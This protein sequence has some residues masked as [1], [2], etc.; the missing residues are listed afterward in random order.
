MKRLPWRFADQGSGR[1]IFTNRT[2]NYTPFNSFGAGNSWG[3][4]PWQTRTG[5]RVGRP[6]LIMG[7]ELGE[8]GSNRFACH[9]LPT[10]NTPPYFNTAEG[11]RAICKPFKKIE[12]RSLS[13]TSCTLPAGAGSPVADHTFTEDDVERVGWIIGYS[14]DLA[15]LH[16]VE[17]WDQNG[18]PLT[19]NG[20]ACATGQQWVDVRGAPSAILIANGGTIDPAEYYA[21]ASFPDNQRMGQM[22][23][24]SCFLDGPP[25]GLF[26][27]RVKTT[28]TGEKARQYNTAI[29]VDRGY[30][31]HF[32]YG[33]ATTDVEDDGVDLWEVSP[34]TIGLDASA[35][36]WLTL[37]GYADAGTA[38]LVIL[39]GR[40]SYETDDAVPTIYV[41]GVA[42]KYDISVSYKA[43]SGTTGGTVTLTIP[44]GHGLQVGGKITVSGMGDNFDAPDVE[45]TAVTDTTV[46]YVW[47]GSATDAGSA[48]A[49]RIVPNKIWV[50]YE[51][52]T[53]AKTS[54]FYHPNYGSGASQVAAGDYAFSIAPFLP[55]TV[56]AI[57]ETTVDMHL[58][59]QTYFSLISFWGYDAA[60]DGDF[61]SP[62]HQKIRPLG[63]GAAQRYEAN[64]DASFLATQQVGLCVY[65]EDAGIAEAAM[66]EKASPFP[67]WSN[68]ASFELKDRSNGVDKAYWRAYNTTTA[69]PAG[70]L[71][72]SKR[73]HWISDGIASSDP[74]FA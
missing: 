50:S 25:D 48:A 70:T 28:Y 60:S 41:D 44:S 33:S 72:S 23:Q 35:N 10:S 56:E 9:F 45:I 29:T 16:L 49:G 14:T 11:W 51:A 32:I 55:F 66:L 36:E 3:G 74:L 65:H 31:T 21:S 46:S 30:H 64:A 67:T 61:A 1:V 68:G 38:S 24:G 59:N 62:G 73:H 58:G 43:R 15:G 13:T 19:P 22:M 18:D 40:H 8:L 26:I 42:V 71:V 47:T 6:G 2:T 34:L 39:G 27:K 7:R 12:T 17:I 20:A 53:G 57:A 37:H 4:N 63:G 69:A 54:K 5:I 52:I